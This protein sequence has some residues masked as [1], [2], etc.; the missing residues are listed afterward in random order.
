MNPGKL[1]ESY[2]KLAGLRTPKDVEVEA[3][4]VAE[5]NRV[6]R[7]NFATIFDLANDESR[8]FPHQMSTRAINLGVPT[9]FGQSRGAYWVRLHTHPQEN[10]SRVSMHFTFKDYRGEETVVSIE[11]YESA[12]GVDAPNC[13]ERAKQWIAS[14]VFDRRGV[15]PDDVVTSR[16]RKDIPIIIATEESQAMIFDALRNPELNPEFAARALQQA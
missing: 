1:H 3:A 7:S 9:G 8:Q 2:K 14:P 16:I 12:V 6:I 10:F 11:D 5:R 13:Y 15:M 4:G